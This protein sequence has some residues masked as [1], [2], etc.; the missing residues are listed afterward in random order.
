[1]R[2]IVGAAVGVLLFLVPS[3]RA[4]QPDSIVS[5][6]RVRLALER[7]QQQPTLTSPTLQPWMAPAPIRLGILTLLPPQTDGQLIRV[8]VPIGDLAT[9]AAHAVSSAQHRRAERK[10][11]ERVQRALQDFQARLPVR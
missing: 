9:R 5:L 7:S 2:I 3:V 4:Q 6:E 10:A 8:A 11:G 1:M